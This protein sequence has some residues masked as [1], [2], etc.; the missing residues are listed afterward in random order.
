MREVSYKIGS[1]VLTSYTKAVAEHDRTHKPIETVL[2][3]VSQKAPELTPVRKAMIEQFGYVSEKF[4][5][6]VVL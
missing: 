5:D 2:T 4:K 6:K 3:E 1:K